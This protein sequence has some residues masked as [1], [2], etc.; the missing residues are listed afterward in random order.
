[1]ISTWRIA[2]ATSLT[3]GAVATV[4]CDRGPSIELARQPFEQAL[5]ATANSADD[6]ERASVSISDD[7]EGARVE[8]SG[9][10]DN[11]RVA[12]EAG[13]EVR[14][15]L[16]EAAE[17]GECDCAGMPQ[18]EAESREGDTFSRAVIDGCTVHAETE[19]E[20]ATVTLDGLGCDDMARVMDLSFEVTEWAA[21]ISADLDE[22]QQACDAAAA[23]TLEAGVH[24]DNCNAIE[25]NIG[26]ASDY[27][28][29]DELTDAQAQ[30]D[31]ACADVGEALELCDAAVADARSAFEGAM[32]AVSSWDS[33]LETYGITVDGESG[34]VHISG[35]EGSV[36]VSEDGVTVEGEEGSVETSED[37]VDIDSGDESLDI[38]ED[39]GD[40]F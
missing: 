25:D 34:E 20:S 37:G 23:D 39:F 35:P 38:D 3:L 8:L 19:S 15:Y 22:A 5:V 32:S 9:A 36:D 16:Q 13:D 28:T 30:L 11:R 18:L 31:E 14:V 2:M 21:D 6:T 24:P 12:I 10:E 7:E 17:A 26:D 29:G 33:A 40:D 27:L 4:G 1:M